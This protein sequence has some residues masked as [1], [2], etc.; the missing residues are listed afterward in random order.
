MSFTMIFV[1]GQV[2]RGVSPGQ[3]VIQVQYQVQYNG[4]LLFHA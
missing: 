1:W 4:Y 3:P 2:F